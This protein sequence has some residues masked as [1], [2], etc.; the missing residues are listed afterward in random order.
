MGFALSVLMSSRI[1]TFGKTNEIPDRR[2][3]CFCCNTAR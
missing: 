3:A 1:S 2:P